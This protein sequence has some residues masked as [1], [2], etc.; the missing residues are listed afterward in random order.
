MFP[1]PTS[2]KICRTISLAFKPFC[3]KSIPKS[4]LFSAASSTR[5]T[6]NLVIVCTRSSLKEGAVVLP[7]SLNLLI[8][9][10]SIISTISSALPVSNSCSAS[11]TSLPLVGLYSY[12]LPE[13]KAV[14]RPT[15][16]DVS[17][18]RPR[19]SNSPNSAAAFLSPL[20]AATLDTPPAA[21]PPST[22]VIPACR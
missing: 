17:V 16:S 6:A 10:P 1:A 5:S 4:I 21:P 18:T 9:L 2:T 15:T 11:R 14:W 22:P 12:P 8:T 20:P 3:V 13:L 19:F 7:T